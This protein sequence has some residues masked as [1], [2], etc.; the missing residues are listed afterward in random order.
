MSEAACPKCGKFLRDLWEYGEGEHDIEC[1]WCD[2]PLLLKCIVSIDY[3]LEE[4]NVAAL[5]E[6]RC[7]GRYPVP[8]TSPPRDEPFEVT[9]RCALPKGHDG[10]HGA[11]ARREP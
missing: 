8:Q 3:E 9:Y 5:R 6:Q 7:E 1:G 11:W 10:P 2:A 4:R